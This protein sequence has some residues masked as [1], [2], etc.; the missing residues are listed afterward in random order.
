MAERNE[1]Q[2]GKAEDRRDSPRVPLRL[3]VRRAGSTDAFEEREGDLSLGGVAWKGNGLTP[4]TAVEVR[5][6]L[7]GSADEVEVRGE[8]LQVTS[9]AQ[10]PAAHVRFVDLPVEAELAIARFLDDVRLSGGDR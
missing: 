6:Q 4:G 2:G 8:V 5:L 9:G 7:P 3:K 10:G 1:S